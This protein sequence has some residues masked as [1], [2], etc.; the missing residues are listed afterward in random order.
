MSF[1]NTPQVIGTEITTS[2]ASRQRY[3]QRFVA[4]FISENRQSKMSD[5][6][7]F[8]KA[9][10]LIISVVYLKSGYKP[11]LK[12]VY[13]V[14]KDLRYTINGASRYPETAFTLDSKIYL[15]LDLAQV[16]NLGKLQKHLLGHTA[17]CD[18]RVQELNLQLDIFNKL[19]HLKAAPQENAIA[20]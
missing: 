13:K 18:R 8:Y 7:D 14:F 2:S 19:Y 9:S 5:R 4:T 3:L 10:S 12:D 15:N 6:I 16:E 11:E 20:S 1:T 17:K